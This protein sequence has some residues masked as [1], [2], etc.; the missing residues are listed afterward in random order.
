MVQYSMRHRTQLYLEDDQY[1]WLKQQAG[2]AGSVAAV[3]RG[4]V[5][6]ARARRA[7]VEGDPFVSYLLDEPPADGTAG[8]SVSTLDHDLYGL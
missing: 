5:D 8:S 7:G 6:D 3:V 4:L 1:R 2:R